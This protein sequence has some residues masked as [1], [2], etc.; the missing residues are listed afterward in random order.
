MT[1]IGNVCLACLRMQVSVADSE[2]VEDCV[3]AHVGDAVFRRLPYYG[4][5]VKR[6]P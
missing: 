2:E 3:E 1:I 6:N 5:G 4:L